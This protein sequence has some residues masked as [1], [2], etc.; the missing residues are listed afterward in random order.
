MK[1]LSIITLVALVFISCGTSGFNKQKYTNLKFHDQKSEQELTDDKEIIEEETSYTDRKEM[2]P[3]EI[4]DVPNITEV[5]DRLISDA[6]ISDEL[7]IDSEKTEI[8]KSPNNSFH[9]DQVSD[10][11]RKD[12][13]TKDQKLRRIGWIFFWISMAFLLTAWIGLGASALTI[14]IVVMIA[15][16]GAVLLLTSIGLLIAARYLKNRRENKPSLLKK[17]KEDEPALLKYEQIRKIAFN[18]LI[19]GLVS[20]IALLFPSLLIIPVGLIIVGSI[21]FLI[22]ME[23]KRR[24]F[25]ENDPAY[26]TKQG[27]KNIVAQFFGWLLTA[28]FSAVGIF[29]WLYFGLGF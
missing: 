12:E 15:S 6:T 27:I 13:R 25:K 16:V 14:I 21:M 5:E 20:L 3:E 29:A 1:K 11:K 4:I 26:E 17:R 18:L 19:A 9:T 22:S 8:T 2:I 23:M 10:K 7:L 24:Y 28:L